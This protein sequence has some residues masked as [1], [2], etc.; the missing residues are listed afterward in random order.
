[1]SLAGKL[2]MGAFGGLELLSAAPWPSD[3]VPDDV[4]EMPVIAD[5]KHGGHTIFLC[6]TVPAQGDQQTATR[7]DRRGQAETLGGYVR[8]LGIPIGRVI[9][10]GQC[11][12]HDTALFAFGRA[13]FDARID[14]PD[15]L[16]TLLSSA[17]TGGTNKVVVGSATAFRELT[18]TDLALAEAAILKPDGH[19]GIAVVARLTLDDWA[20]VAEDEQD[21]LQFLQ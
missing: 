3:G 11:G 13:E 4:D 16:R 7:I 1:M 20:Q 12:A 9:A 14:D 18:G 8:V 21:A 10:G 5:L 19:G 6:H 17:P 2:L 15:F